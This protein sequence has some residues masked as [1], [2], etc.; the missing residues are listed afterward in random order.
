MPE[1]EK[2]KADDY[3]VVPSKKTRHEISVVGTREKAV[4]TSSV[5]RTS[6]LY[7]PIMLLEG[8]QGEI[9]TARFH[10]EGKHLA[11][12]GFDRQIFVWNVYGQ[13]ENIMVMKG[14]TGAIMEIN[15]SPDGSHLY[16][17]ATD[18]TVAVWD[19]PTGTRIKKLKGHANFV[20]SVSGARRG[21]ELLASASDDNTIKLWD[22]RKRNPVASFDSEYPVTAVLFNDT[23][24]KIISGGIDNVVKV[25]D[26][27]TNKISYKIK[28]HTDTITGLALSYDGSYLLSN[29][30]DSTLRIWDVRAFAPGERCVKLLAGH[31]HNFERNLL[32]CAWS[33]DGSK[34]TA[35]SSDR[36]V[37]VWDT[38]SRRV[39][40]K[41]PGHRGA[42]T[43]AGFHPREPVVLSAGSDKLLYLGEIEP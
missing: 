3:S 1:L 20:N 8:H 39:L 7:A 29:A 12:A 40:Y 23:A 18:N 36:C 10:P 25:W 26:I 38:T 11:S 5:P 19:V 31:H 24:E 21:P 32:R 4:V 9:F 28:G 43:D 27:R 15:F 14:H 17:C 13:C 37:H 16:S 42:V 41:L 34:V 2:R 6:N 22:A 35:G 33:S 30:M